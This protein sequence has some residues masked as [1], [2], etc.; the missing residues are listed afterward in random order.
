MGEGEGGK[1]VGAFLMWNMELHES[2]VRRYPSSPPF[3]SLPFPSIC[4]PNPKFPDAVEETADQAKQE[5]KIKFVVRKICKKKRKKKR[6]K[7]EEKKRDERKKFVHQKTLEK[8]LLKLK[9]SWMVVEFLF[10]PHKS[11][12]CGV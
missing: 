10:E 3:P 9:E 1:K 4:E 2:G 8:T 12:Y 7:K 11:G 6:K 5:A